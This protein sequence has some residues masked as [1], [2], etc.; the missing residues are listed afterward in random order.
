MVV[1]PSMIPRRSGERI[2]TDRRDSIML[3][4]LHRA[5]E[6]TAVVNLRLTPD[7]LLPTHP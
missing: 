3:A 4:S 2:K 5:G 1:A 7:G 6:L